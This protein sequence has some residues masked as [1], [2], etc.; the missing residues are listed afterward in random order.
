[1]TDQELI[2]KIARIIEQTESCND[3]PFG[4]HRIR[5]LVDA[6]RGI[7][8]TGHC[9]AMPP[10]PTRRELDCRTGRWEMTTTE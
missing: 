1:M 9:P 3:A 10:L 4:Y 2:E 7:V 5:L 6:H 8:R